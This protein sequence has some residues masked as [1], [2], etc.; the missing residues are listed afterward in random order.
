MGKGTFPEALNTGQITGQDGPAR[1]AQ[2]GLQRGQGKCEG[3]AG[4]LSQQ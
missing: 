2:N 3:P 4:G 1:E